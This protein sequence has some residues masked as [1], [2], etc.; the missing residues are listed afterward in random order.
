MTGNSE[1][2]LA[3][4]LLHTF[5]CCLGSLNLAKYDEWKDTDTVALAIYFLEAVMSE[6]LERAQNIRGL[7]NAV[8]FAQKSRALG[9][10]V[11]G[12]HTYLQSKQIAFESKEAS[13]F[14][15]RVFKEIRAKAEK[16]SAKLGDLFGYPEWCVDLRRRHSHLLA[17]APT[18]T[19]SI[20][21][22]VSRAIEPIEV[23]CGFTNGA[24]GTF[25]YANEQLVPILNKYNQNTDLIWR[26]IA[27]KGGS[28]QHLDFLSEA[29]RK[30]FKTARE[31]DQ[32]VL[33][34]LAIDRGIYIDQGQSLNLFYNPDADPEEV[35]ATH[36]LAY[37][38]YEEKPGLKSLYYL[39]TG[40]KLKADSI[41]NPSNTKA[42]ENPANNQECTVCQ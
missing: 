14:N 40:S 33:V 36:W 12:F 5:V 41:L 2:F 24:K 6:F 7:E 13:E 1:I 30:V 42:I 29:E 34:K 19:N 3:T 38:G 26:S 10:G 9:L 37:T 20:V 11:L 16:A 22:A 28:V 32:Q 8:R 25:T 35:H 15:D 17:C 23:N 31:I 18:L 39:K 4:D 27:A 21:C